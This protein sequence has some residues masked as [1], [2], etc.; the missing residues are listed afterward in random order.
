MMEEK[1]DYKT[2]IRGK[3][4]KFRKWKVKDK[5]KFLRNSNNKQLVRE[6]LVYDVVQ[7]Q[8]LALSEEE[9][10]YLLL[11]IREESIK[12]PMFMNIEC[13]ECNTDFNYEIKIP[14]VVSV[15][16]D[17]NYT[18]I[19]VGKH[20]F[21]MSDIKNRAFYQ[22]LMFNSVDED[23][24]ILIDFICHIDTYNDQDFSFEEINDII[25]NLNVEEF[26]KIMYKWEQMRFKV[27]TLHEVEC[28]N[29]KYKEPFFFD[30]FP[31]FFPD[32]WVL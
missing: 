31:G 23:E 22:D 11:K 7:D 9:Y 30:D 21:K 20:I 29:C 24:K 5:K 18:D 14:E 4:I 16:G 19:E 6:A 12:N 26:E 17:E 13:S 3:I 32:T 2:E 28:P 10:R 15:A 25:I 1:Y 8:N 27:N